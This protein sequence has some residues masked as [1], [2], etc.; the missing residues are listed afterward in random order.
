MESE[1]KL[2]EEYRVGHE[3]VIALNETIWQI[4]GILVGTSLGAFAIIAAFQSVTKMSLLVSIVVATVS[5]SLLIIWYLLMER[6]GSFIR[7]YYYR[8]REIEIELGLWRNRY[9]QYLDGVQ[10]DLAQLSESERQRLQRVEAAFRGKYSRL[11]GTTVHRLMIA[12]PPLIW[13]CWIIYQAI[14]LFT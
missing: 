4:A 3:M 12:L 6:A 7:V 10:T 9:I 1:K 2:L 13:I 8:M 11:R 5:T 14:I